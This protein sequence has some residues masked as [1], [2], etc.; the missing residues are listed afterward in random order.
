M[1]S[2]VWLPF[3][4]AIV[5][6]C[7]GDEVASSVTIKTENAESCNLYL[8]DGSTYELKPVGYKIDRVSIMAQV[9][10]ILDVLTGKIKVDGYVPSLEDRSYVEQVSLA[11]D[12]LIVHLNA[13]FL[14]Q[15]QSKQLIARSSMI[16]S[17]SQVEEVTSIEFYIEGYPMKDDTG[18]VYGAFKAAD[19]AIASVTDEPLLTSKQ[20]LLYFPDQSGNGL[21]KVWRDIIVSST[22][23]FEERLVEE[24]FSPPED[25][26]VISPMPG[27]AQIKSVRIS[28]G[29]C[30]VDMNEAFKSKHYGGSTGEKLT[31]YSIVNTLTEQH[32]ISRVQ[33]LIEGEKEAA[34]KGHL[35]FDQLFTYNVTL[36]LKD[37]SIEE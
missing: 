37:Y 4:L 22:E 1:R 35:A 24:L 3:L 34:F 21:V 9:D 25:D 31:V 7:Q 6:G 2:W 18:K 33:F 12:T 14:E 29:I 16:L 5:V 17:L 10:D 32:G 19:V 13:A 26:R 27:E 23:N 30:Y 11:K 28:N 8:L 36:V 20:I 15:T